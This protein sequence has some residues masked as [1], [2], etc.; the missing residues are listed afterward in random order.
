MGK[1]D[2]SKCRVAPMMRYMVENKS[3]LVR[4]LGVMDIDASITDL[5]D[6]DIYFG[7]KDDLTGEKGE[8]QLVPSCEYL[9]RLIEELPENTFAIGKI[10]NSQSSDTTKIRRKL[11]YDEKERKKAIKYIK[12]HYSSLPDD[13]KGAYYLEG[14]SKPDVF[15]ETLDKVIVIEGKWTESMPTEVTTYCDNRNQMVRHIHDA[16]NYVRRSGHEKQVFGFYIVADLF[17]KEWE[18]EIST[19]GFADKLLSQ[20]GIEDEIDSIRAAYKGYITWERI[21]QMFPGVV[22]QSRGWKED[23]D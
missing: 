14:S 21:V 15:I 5:K 2:S 16:L 7:E 12:N 11:I 18:G 13:Y 19:L 3:D 22:D 17:A 20:Y 4:L 1:N 9:C 8:K 10:N 6:E 23:A